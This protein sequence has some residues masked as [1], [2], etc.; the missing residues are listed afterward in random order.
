MAS[1]S[2][3]GSSATGGNRREQLAHG[4]AR[5]AE[6]LEHEQGGRRGAGVTLLK[7]ATQE[8]PQICAAEGAAARHAERRPV[9][10]APPS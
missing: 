5:A 7:P 2:E 6:Q 8:W 4:A 9:P 1:P 3:T 10:V